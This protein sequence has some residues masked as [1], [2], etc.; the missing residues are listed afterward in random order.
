MAKIPQQ[1]ARREIP[2]GRVAGAFIPTSLADVGQGIEAQGL[3]DI[4][5]GVSG[6]GVALGKIAFA[7]GTSE[8]STARGLAE[9]EIRLLESRLQRNPDPATY[10]DELASSLETIKG[11]R[12]ESAIGGKQFDDFMTDAIPAWQTGVNILRIDRSHANTEGAY[13]SNLAGAV[14]RGDVDEIDRLIDEAENTTGVISPQRAARDRV[15]SKKTVTGVLDAR[16]IDTVVSQALLFTVEEGVAQGLPDT[17]A[18]LKSIRE[19]GLS[20]SNRVD[21][22]TI[23]NALVKQQRDAIDVQREADRDK[24]NTLLATDKLT[25]G[26]INSTSLSETEQLSYDKL[27]RSWAKDRD[28]IITD[29]RVRANLRRSVVNIWRGANTKTQVMALLN[30]ARF[31]DDPKIDDAA[32]KELAIL[33]ETKLEKVQGDFLAEAHRDGQEQLLDLTSETQLA[34]IIAGRLTELQSERH[35]TQ[36]WW[37]DRYDNEMEQWVQ[38]NPDKNK[39]EGHQEAEMRL[40]TYINTPFEEIDTLRTRTLAS[41]QQQDARRREGKPLSEAELKGAITDAVAT[42][43]QRVVDAE[44]LRIRTEG[45]AVATDFLAKHPLAVQMQGPTGVPIRASLATIGNRLDRGDVFPPG[46][47]VMVQRNTSDKTQ[48]FQGLTVEPNGRVISFDGGKTWQ[49]LP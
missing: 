14:A 43:K 23:Y 8:A 5:R 6:L 19:S 32:Y 48:Q 44:K 29:E 24:L 13:I 47:E 26:E 35:Q 45:E 40:A 39:R 9:S 15:A 20:P 10:N 21:A 3:A 41:L 49:L 1:V 12:P 33:A 38:E 22:N 37:A 36:L 17:K 46:S 25:P 30:E 18:G 34:L 31:G 28:D 42:E 4:G 2:S 11:F 16:D 27:Y 7:E